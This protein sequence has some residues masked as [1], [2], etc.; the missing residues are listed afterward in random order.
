M[1]HHSKRKRRKSAFL[2]KKK[3]EKVLPSCDQ[4]S[5]DAVQP[6]THGTTD[7]ITIVEAASALESTTSKAKETS[8]HA[9]SDDNQSTPSSSTSQAAAA[10]F[11]STKHSSRKNKKNN[12]FLCSKALAKSNGKG[13]KF[14]QRVRSMITSS[15]CDD[16]K[17]NALLSYFATQNQRCSGS[18]KPGFNSS[19]EE[20]HEDGNNEEDHN[21]DDVDQWD[22]DSDSEVEVKVKKRKKERERKRAQRRMMTSPEREQTRANDRNR[23][24]NERCESDQS[25]TPFPPVVTEEQ[26]K[27]CIKSYI[28]ATSSSVLKETACGICAGLT[29]KFEILHINEIPSRELLHK[30][31]NRG[32]TNLPEYIHE[33]LLLYLDAVNNDMVNC[34]STCLSKLRKGKI[35]PLSIANNMQIGKTPDELCGLTLPEKLL[36]SVYRPKMYV[37]TFRSI[38]GPGTGQRGLK[39]N[40]ITFPQDVVGV[41]KKLPPRMDLL[42]EIIKVIF[43]GPRAPS[44]DTIKKVFTVRRIKIDGALSFLQ[45]NHPLYRE[46]E[47][48]STDHLPEDDVPEEIWKMV[49]H[50]GDLQQ[51]DQNEHASY[52]GEQSHPAAQD[53]NGEIIMDSSGVLDVAGESVSSNSQLRSAVCQLQGTLVV[54]HGHMPLT[55]YNNPLLWIG[56]YPWLFPYGLGGPEICRPVAVSLRTYVKHLLLHADPKFRLDLSFKFHVFNILQKRDVCL[57]SSLLLHSSRS[58]HLVSQ[59]GTLTHTMLVDLLKA[60]EGNSTIDPRLK[61]LL[62]NL[63]STGSKV[64]GSPYC[65][66]SYRREIFGLMISYGMPAFFITVSPSSIHSPLVLFLAGK[67]IDLDNLVPEA[68]LNSH[69]RAQVAAKDPVA[70]ARFFN[71]VIDAFCD[72]L[73]GYN[74]DDGGVVGKVSAY[75]GCIEE[76]GTGTLHIHMLVWLK[77]FSSRADLERNFNTE[78]FKTDLLAY[79]EQ[80]IQQGFLGEAEFD[81]TGLDVS[82]VSCARPVDPD[83]AEFGTKLSLDVN[84]LVAIANTHRHTFTC[85]KCKKTDECRFGFPRPLVDISS[86]DENDIILRRTNEN[87]NN[88]NP[89][90]MTCVRCNHDIKFIPSGKDGRACVF[91]M[92]DY[93]TKASLSTHQMA[94]LI[95][96]SMKNL[97]IHAP[98]DQSLEKRSQMLVT[99]VLNRVTTETELSAPHVCHFLL[100][101]ADKKT[102]HTFSQLNLHAALKWLYKEERCYDD[103]FGSDSE[104]EDEA[105]IGHFIEQG[106]VGLVLINQMTDYLYRGGELKA[107]CLYRYV[108]HIMKSKFT[109]E[110]K[111]KVSDSK[112]PSV[113]PGRKLSA[114]YLFSED[115]PQS[116][117]HFQKMRSNPIVPSLSFLPP[118]QL[119]DEEKFMICMLLLFKP[120]EKFDDL[121]NGISW[122]DSFDSHDFGEDA[123]FV[124]NLNQMHIGLEERQRNSNE[125]D[126]P[127]R[128]DDDLAVVDDVD[129]ALPDDDIAPDPFLTDIDY[130]L[131][132]PLESCIPANAINNADY[133]EISSSSLPFKRKCWDREMKEQAQRIE[134]NLCS[135]I[136][137]NEIEESPVT[138][139][140]GGSRSYTDHIDFE[141]SSQH[142]DPVD[143]DG[144]LHDAKLQY[145]LNPKQ[146]A[147]FDLITSNTVKRLRGEPCEQIIAYIGGAGG[148]GKSQ[149]IKATVH[150]YESLNIRHYLRLAAYTGTAAKLIRGK[151]LSSIA[152]LR[153]R[154]SAKLE[155]L[156]RS[157]TT[158]L[159]DEVSMV[160]CRLLAKLSKNITK[161]K[162]GSPCIPFGGVDMFF[163]GD[164]T[165]FPP[166]KDTPLYHQHQKGQKLNIPE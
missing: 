48:I 59:I 83:D 79:L 77:G 51:E 161:A 15:S 25:N 84:S 68:L 36:I 85:Y 12:D 116:D 87:I 26:I 165:Q 11:S 46:V 158:T 162:H 27:H 99:K 14:R 119:Y 102:S 40:T 34:C 54:P 143:I 8:S 131:L 117:T 9:I 67:E 6:L 166:V 82:T 41:S 66:K 128:G 13:K 73:L 122:R 139:N 4:L 74:Q 55:D 98:S 105:D 42:S 18:S 71:I 80:S 31:S 155:K 50:H 24:E 151:T 164:F 21:D 58:S 10:S 44:K 76:Q 96:S 43:I 49:S 3:K 154:S 124:E 130:H 94:P 86:I 140:P 115:H 101:H 103:I 17:K 149:I 70:V 137:A 145:C 38:A 123:K 111:R 120:F 134:A 148:T 133:C 19:D 75:Y 32:Q 147:T 60:V 106:N 81:T 132:Q 163:F 57:H 146:A 65:K 114:R 61:T 7:E 22:S 1:D 144:L 78:T 135:G 136:D 129:T 23:K 141:I 20:A 29:N 118:S 2:T 126:I 35:P 91:Y 89:Y 159:V 121:F 112:N 150:F 63:S 52:T 113:K 110:E 72:H 39:G 69:E 108:S 45:A 30:D 125:E 90:F 93:T 157:V 47:M 156:W 92:T 97:E 62:D 104:N 153:G 160:G 100:G 95:A 28:Q 37:T 5:D 107:M 64:A 88:Y 138:D 142:E 152:A 127:E 33:D 16:L 109:E 56:A 53:N